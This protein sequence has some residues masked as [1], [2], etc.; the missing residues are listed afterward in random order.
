[1][2]NRYFSTEGNLDFIYANIVI[3][4]INFALIS[5]HYIL[6][7]SDFELS[8]YRDEHSYYFF[9]IQSVLTACGNISNIF[10]NYGGQG[11]RTATLRSQRLRKVF[12]ISKED[13]P[14][15][16]QKEVRNTNAHFDERYEQ[17][18]GNVGDYNLLDVD[19]DT[20]MR[21]TILNNPHLRTYDKSNGIYYTY[22]RNLQQI[23]YNLWHLRDELSDMI[24]KIN[25]NSITN[26]AW[27]DAI[28]DEK[29]KDR[30]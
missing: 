26:V 15:T 7:V 24:Y 23:E 25:E 10:Y 8:I 6:D 13:Y 20:T 4:N 2:F 17:F 19:T 21:N 14:L 18:N 9:H 22:N 5:L 16:F 12:N 29:V 11:G 1:M 28:P 27:V 30:E 3:K